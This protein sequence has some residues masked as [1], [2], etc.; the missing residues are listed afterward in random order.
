M[1]RTIEERTMALEKAMELFLEHGFAGASVEA[2]VQA[3]G[4]NRYAIYETFGDKLG[5]FRAALGYYTEQKI[6]RLHLVRAAFPGD[7]FRALQEAIAEPVDELRSG[8]A[9]CCLFSVAAHEF[10]ADNAELTAQF[11]E[12][13]ARMRAA[14]ADMLGQAH[15]EGTARSDISPES[16]A[17]L[18]F[19][20]IMGMAAQV[21]AGADPSDIAAVLEAMLTALSVPKA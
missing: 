19:T 9:K 20:T 10:G 18:L 17:V 16:G 2:V 12:C 7:S 4:L 14:I 15:I 5:L 6:E 11:Q 3:T 21:R 8:V 1:P 13:A